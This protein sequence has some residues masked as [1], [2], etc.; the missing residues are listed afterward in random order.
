[1]GASRAKILG[2]CLLVIKKI[3]VKISCVE[4]QRFGKER[5]C[6]N[7][8]VRSVTI[9]ILSMTFMNDQTMG[10]VE[11]NNLGELDVL[12]DAVQEKVIVF[13]AFISSI[14]VVKCSY[15]EKIFNILSDS[16]Y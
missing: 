2:R 4:V 6:R 5:A 1:M 12:D 7:R 9:F 11:L 8:A 10:Y 3:T 16:F 13:E 14:D 15:G